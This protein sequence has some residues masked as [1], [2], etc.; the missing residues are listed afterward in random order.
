[1]IETAA[2]NQDERKMGLEW[3]ANCPV[4]DDWVTE[5]AAAQGYELVQYCNAAY[6]GFWS[7]EFA[8]IGQP[9]SV[10]DVITQRI[11]TTHGPCEDLRPGSVLSC[12]FCGGVPGE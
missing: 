6:N 5:L 3:V 11:V 7:N 9:Q 2:D 12:Q 10:S 1:V 8:W 4:V